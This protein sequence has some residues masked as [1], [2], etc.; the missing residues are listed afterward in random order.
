VKAY[1]VMGDGPAPQTSLAPLVRYED[2]VASGT[3]DYE[4]PVFDENE[5]A[6]MC[7]TS[8]TTGNPKASFTP[9]RAVL[10]CAPSAWPMFDPERDVPSVPISTRTPGSSPVRRW[11]ASRRHP[12][13]QP[14][15]QTS[16]S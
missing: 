8:G 11:S 9:P 14:T 4:F 3:D 13:V 7:Y 12:G 5:A 2:L 10:Q 6:A 1:V 16:P 15:P